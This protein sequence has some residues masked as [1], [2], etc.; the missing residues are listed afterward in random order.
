MVLWI[1][2][3][4]FTSLDSQQPIVCFIMVLGINGIFEEM[5][6]YVDGVMIIHTALVYIYEIT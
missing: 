2:L 1:T 6:I 5:R 3:S 4:G